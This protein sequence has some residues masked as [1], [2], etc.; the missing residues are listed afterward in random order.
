MNEGFIPLRMRRFGGGYRPED[1]VIALGE[2]RLSI[3]QL[4]SELE[5]ARRRAE[6]AETQARVARTEADSLRARERELNDAATSAY[7]HA[8][9]V[10]QTAQ[11]R[12]A[13]I[14]AQAEEQAARTRTDAHLQVE[15]TAQQFE[16]LLRLKAELSQRLRGVLREFEDAVARVEQGRPVTPPAQA[17]PATRAWEIEI[18][19]APPPPREG[20][21]AIF[22]PHVEL[23][24]GP[25]GDFAS[26]SAFERAVSQLPRMDDVYVRRFDG[27]RAWIEVTMSERG[28]FLR[29]LREFAGYDFEASRLGPNAVRL[30]VHAATFA[31]A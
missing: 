12:A 14:L 23:D 6:D 16:E 27:E 17:A 4:Q 22:E 19:D 20:D 15:E 18:P 10:E 11:A 13:A 24:A 29:L 8:A 9:E 25:F 31:G 5:A 21:D 3:R 2:L 28:P 30:D 1:V 26:L 7:A